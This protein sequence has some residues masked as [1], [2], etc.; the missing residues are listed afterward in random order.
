MEQMQKSIQKSETESPNE[1]EAMMKKNLQNTILIQFQ[2]TFADSQAIEI[3][4]KEKVKNKI[5][6]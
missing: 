2:K 1:P 6:R 5:R 3:S 4:F